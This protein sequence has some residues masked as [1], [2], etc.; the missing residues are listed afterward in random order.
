MRI[1]VPKEVAGST[2]FVGRYLPKALLGLVVSGLDKNKD[3]AMN[4][5]LKSIGVKH[6]V[7]YIL[8]YALRRLECSIVGTYG[9]I[10]VSNKLRLDGYTLSQLCRLIDFGNAEVRGLNAVNGALNSISIGIMRYVED[11]LTEI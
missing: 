5:Y 3:M 9:T 4:A 10:E 11:Y 6:S 1:E 8:K 2:D 7:A